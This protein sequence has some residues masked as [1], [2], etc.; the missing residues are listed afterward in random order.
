MLL[1]YQHVSNRRQMTAIPDNETWQRILDIAEDLFSK[2]GYA[3]VRLRDIS[4]QIGIKHS[5][6]YYYMPD[7]KEQLYVEVMRRNLHRHSTGMEQ[8]I[9]EAEFDLRSQL[10]AAG[11][12]LLSQPP[13]NISRMELSD[14][15]AIKPENAR[16]LS[17]MVY[18]SMRMPIRNALET[19]AHNGVVSFPDLDLAAISFI[20]LMESIHTAETPQV[21]ENREQIMESLVDML[22]NG[23]LRR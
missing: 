5:A 1:F 12:W 23:W 20:G 2:R 17:G 15:P 9:Q 16:M 10:V 21:R 14:F 7:G 18:D 8:A 19:A 11:R 6:L 3:S 13:M 22:L 4:D